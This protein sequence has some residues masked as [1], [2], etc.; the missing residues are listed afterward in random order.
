MHHV[1]IECSRNYQTVRVGRGYL[2]R[3]EVRKFDLEEICKKFQPK[4]ASC[5]PKL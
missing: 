4:M 1:V 5:S 2:I 3:V